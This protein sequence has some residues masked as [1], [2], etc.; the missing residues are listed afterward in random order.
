MHKDQAI[1]AIKASKHV[2]CEKPMALTKADCEAIR[3]ALR[4]TDLLFT[5]LFQTRAVP[6]IRY[7]HDVIE[8]GALGTLTLCD[9]YMKYW[10][11]ESYFNVSPWR[12]TF[13][14]DGGGAL[15]NQGIHGVDVMH[16]LCGKPRLLGAKVKTLVHKIE[17]EDTAVALCEYPSGALGVIE[18]TTTANPGFERRI[19]ICGSRGYAV[20]I[21]SSLEKLVID[22]KTVV[23]KEA[24]I[25]AGTASN[26][27]AMGHA[28][29]LGLYDNL[30]R[31]Y[32]GE[33]EL[34]STV[35]DG[36]NSVGFVED[37]YTLS[38][39]TV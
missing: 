8:S 23:E 18:A 4:G 5:V 24:S 33:E 39:K 2:I 14:M 27:S 19:E 29:H 34:Y 10:R 30:V 38:G 7:L 37:V 26:P 12:G 20:V 35:D 15:M 25:A 28:Y 1:A 3:E 9:L 6:D 17:T 13:E 21:D 32:R 16:Y 11:D 22:G 31:A 36:Y